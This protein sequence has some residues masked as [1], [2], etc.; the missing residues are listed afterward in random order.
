MG[1]THQPPLT[2]DVVQAAQQESTEP[3]RFLD[4]AK[5]GFDDDLPP[6]IQ[7]FPF[8]GP[9]FRCHAF[10]RGGKQGGKL[11]GLRGMVALASFAMYGSNSSCSTVAAAPAL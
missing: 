4:L 9:H 10:F 5:H 7:R 3:T 11:A 6:G 1:H 2:T 8:R